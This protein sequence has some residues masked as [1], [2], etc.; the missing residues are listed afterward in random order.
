[1]AQYLRSKGGVVVNH[2]A[3]LVTSLCR[4][5]SQNN[6]EKLKILIEQGA[7]VNAGDYDRRTGKYQTSFLSKCPHFDCV[8]LFFFLVH[9][10]HKFIYT[11]F[12]LSH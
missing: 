8:I 3:D 6:V 11:Y 10:I 7:D 9:F 1:V 4:A 2:D 12:T 5:A